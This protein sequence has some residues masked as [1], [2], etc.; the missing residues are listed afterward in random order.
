[1][2]A[3]LVAWSAAIPAQQ[4]QLQIIHNAADPAAFVFD[5]YINDELAVDDL[6]FRTASVFLDVPANVDNAISL[7]F[8]ESTSVYDAFATY[9]VRLPVGKHYAVASGVYQ[10]TEF[11]SSPDANAKPI[12]F[13]VMTFEDRRTTSASSNSVDLCM[14][15]GVTDAP[16][17]DVSVG[18][19]TLASALSFGRATAYITAAADATTVQVA[20][21]SGQ[22]I[23]R[24]T[25]DLRS[26]SS[27][28]LGVFASGFLD[29]TRNQQG[30]AFGLW[31]LLPTGGPLIPLT[32]VTSRVDGTKPPSSLLLAPNPCSSYVCVRGTE[33][34]ESITIRNLIGTLILEV[35]APTISGVCTINTSALAP[36]TYIVRVGAATQLL[37]VLR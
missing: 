7:A 24:F 15:H 2:C 29:P 37:H 9:L 31:L 32:P 10:P 4:A 1:M 25:A 26:Y 11:A 34:Q 5:V 6:T 12:A 21:S 18:A 27:G 23:G 16:A 19:Q 28:A 8:R 33:A 17:L 35:Q 20:A 14:I 3:L 13:T 30:P 22:L 36:G